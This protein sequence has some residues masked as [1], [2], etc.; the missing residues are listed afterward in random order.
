MPFVT[1]RKF[2]S[3]E[4]LIETLRE[5]IWYGGMKLNGKFLLHV[6]VT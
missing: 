3:V 5:I 6:F 1:Q 4:W 2:F